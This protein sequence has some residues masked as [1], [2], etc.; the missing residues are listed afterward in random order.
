MR[1]FTSIALSFA[2][3]L[4]M[5]SVGGGDNVAAQESFDCGSLEGLQVLHSTLRELADGGYALFGSI[6]E[7]CRQAYLDA[8]AIVGVE[9]ETGGSGDASFFLDLDFSFEM[10][11]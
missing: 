6:S 1:H 4:S 2:F 10:A 3:V 11:E 5:S 7:Q 8:Q 9:V